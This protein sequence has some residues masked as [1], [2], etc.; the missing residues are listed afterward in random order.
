[1]AAFAA[2]FESGEIVGVKFT[3][4]YIVSSRTALGVV[5]HLSSFLPFL[6]RLFSLI[7]VSGPLSVRS[8]NLI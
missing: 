2:V 1:M 8:T 3:E 5:D 6:F 7:L 4:T